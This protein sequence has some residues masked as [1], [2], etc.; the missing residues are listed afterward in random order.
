[1]DPIGPHARNQHGTAGDARGPDDP[2]HEQVR[3]NAGRIDCEARGRQVCGDQPLFRSGGTDDPTGAHP[4]RAAT[5][6]T[7][8]FTPAY[9]R[10]PA[11]FSV[12]GIEPRGSPSTPRFVPPTT[13]QLLPARPSP[14]GGCYSYFTITS[15]RCD[16]CGAIPPAC[17][18][19]SALRCSRAR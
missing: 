1:G 2:R 11:L 14:L 13:C 12:D 9:R 19:D 6:E 8:T 4:A 5:E 10:A 7:V 15:W 18:G 3:P 17:D 16:I